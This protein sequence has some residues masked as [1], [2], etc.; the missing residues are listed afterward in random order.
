MGYTP[1]QRPWS[2]RNSNWQGIV[3]AFADLPNSAGSPYQF[4]VPN[5]QHGDLAWVRV[6]VP[7][8]YQCVDP[9]LGAAVWVLINASPPPAPPPSGIF[10]PNASM[11]FALMPGDN[12]ATIAVD[13]AVLFPQDGPTS[14][15]A[16]V[17]LSTSTFNV[18]TAGL[19]QVSWQ[20][21]ITEPAQ[22][23]L[24]VAGTPLAYSVASRATGTTQVSNTV[25]VQFVA[26][27]V[28][29]V[30]N[31]SGNGAALTMTPSDGNLTHAVGATLTI[32]RVA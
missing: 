23:M 13:A 10:T 21:D 29:E 32:V 26:N 24:R 18:P 6:G 12:A 19:Y 3:D 2:Q 31:P 20:C 15:P 27:D 8:L 25:L 4:G 11:F 28:V 9:T 1:G 5:V 17:R 7:G 22:L 16:P 14:G 30:I